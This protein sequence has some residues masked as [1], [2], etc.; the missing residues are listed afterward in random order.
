M[1][2]L[3]GQILRFGF[4]AVPGEAKVV[5]SYN[6][7]SD[8]IMV[9]FMYG[10]I[11]S[12]SIVVVLTLGGSTDLC[13]SPDGRSRNLELFRGR[14]LARGLSAAAAFGRAAVC[15]LSVSVFIC[16]CCSALHCCTALPHPARLLSCRRLGLALRPA[17]QPSIPIQPPPP[18]CDSHCH[19]RSEQP[20]SQCTLPCRLQ[21]Y[22]EPCT[23][24]FEQQPHAHSRRR[25]QAHRRPRPA[26]SAACTPLPP[27]HH[28]SAPRAAPRMR[29]GLHSVCCSRPPASDWH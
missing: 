19:T 13:W 27:A 21:R 1:F 12:P 3:P 16:V 10:F 26:S 20:Q 28:R 23:Q 5:R 8:E 7:H 24:P 11:V 22:D 18:C 25:S 9:L 4:V 15:Q 17:R 2:N 14:S 29:R 6:L